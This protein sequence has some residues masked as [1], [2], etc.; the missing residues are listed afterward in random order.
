[1]IKDTLKTI[2]E[3]NCQF[4]QARKKDEVIALIHPDSLSYTQ[5]KQMVEQLFSSYHLSVLVIVFKFMGKDKTYA[6]ARVQQEIKKI[7]GP[8]F[9]DN[10]TDQ[11]IVFKQDGDEWK[12]WTTAV[13]NIKYID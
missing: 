1:V 7:S 13:L 5:T 4:T 12:I 3:K 6:Y 8:E 10:I 11:L 9:K 2:V